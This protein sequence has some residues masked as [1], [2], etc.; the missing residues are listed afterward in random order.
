MAIDGRAVAYKHDALSL[1]FLEREIVIAASLPLKP[2]LP[3]LL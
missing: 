3:P 1:G 2:S